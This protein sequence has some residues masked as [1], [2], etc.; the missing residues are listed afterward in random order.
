M[1]SSL[2]ESAYLDSIISSYASSFVLLLL[3]LSCD[4]D[5]LRRFIASS[6]SLMDIAVS[7]CAKLDDK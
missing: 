6:S 4:E 2:S 1:T 3:Q 5:D 7:S